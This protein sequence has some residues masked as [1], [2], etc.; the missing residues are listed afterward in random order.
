M[1][2]MS[3][4]F[5]FIIIIIKIIIIIHTGLHCYDQQTR[6]VNFQ[7]RLMIWDEYIC[8]L[9]TRQIL[10][11][12]SALPSKGTSSF[13]RRSKRWI[14]LRSSLTYVQD[15]APLASNSSNSSKPSL[16]LASR[17][18]FT[19]GLAKNFI[20]LSSTSDKEFEISSSLCCSEKP[21]QEK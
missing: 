9:Q 4:I 2:L 7:K 3:I 18:G 8:T 10:L 21:D 17:K 19:L 1:Y 6:T 14:P 16:I 15:N 12:L 20:C 11:P 13:S 5:K